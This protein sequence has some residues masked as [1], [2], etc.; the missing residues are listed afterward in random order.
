MD[1]R[2][3]AADRSRHGVAAALFAAVLFGAGTPVAKQLLAGIEHEHEHDAHHVHE[4]A[5]QPAA[6]RHSHL[7]RRDELRHSHAHFPD[8]HHRH[9]H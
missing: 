1:E 2:V 8:E 7:H 9:S 4:H 6:L 3:M 5:G